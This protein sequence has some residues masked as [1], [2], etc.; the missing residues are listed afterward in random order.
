MCDRIFLVHMKAF[1]ILAGLKCLFPSVCKIILLRECFVTLAALIRFFSSV[2]GEKVFFREIPIYLCK[3]ESKL[4]LY[5]KM[6]VLTV[7]IYNVIRSI[8]VHTGYDI[9]Y[10]FEW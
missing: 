2:L 9:S 5:V 8:V 1:V 10:E 6:I 4:C 7:Y 3:W